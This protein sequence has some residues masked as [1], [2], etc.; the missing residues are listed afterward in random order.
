ML[1]FD[2]GCVTMHIYKHTCTEG[3]NHESF[4]KNVSESVS[5]YCV[6][7]FPR[8][9]L[10]IPCVNRSLMIGTVHIGGN[11]GPL[12]LKITGTSQ[13]LALS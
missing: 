12:S 13:S 4:C 11:R 6:P 9:N 5:A 2:L 1:S 10:V 7:G 8:S 3:Y